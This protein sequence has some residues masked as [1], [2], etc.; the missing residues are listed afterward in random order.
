MA[1]SLRPEPSPDLAVNQR[2]HLSALPRAAEDR[3]LS[4]DEAAEVL[5]VSAYVVRQWARERRIPAVRLGQRYWRF[6]RSSLDAWI[7]DQERAARVGGLKLAKWSRD[8]R[9]VISGPQ[10]PPI[11]RVPPIG[12]GRLD[13]SHSQSLV[14]EYGVHGPSVIR[15]L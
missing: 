5:Q 6:R 10:M 12:F 7:A 1:S 4:V 15:R 8:H 13:G 3:L 2:S 11:C 9:R 14:P